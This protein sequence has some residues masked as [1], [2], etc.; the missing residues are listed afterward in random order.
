MNSHKYIMSK[1]SIDNPIDGTLKRVHTEVSDS[2]SSD[3]KS[4]VKTLNAKNS[5]VTSF[6][7][8][9]RFLIIGSTDEGALQKL[10]PFAIDKGLQGWAGSLK[11][12][13]KL[14][15]GTLLVECATDGH[16]RSLL[17]SG[18]LCNVPIKVTPHSS[19]NSCKGVIR[20]RD[21]EGVGEEEICENLTSQGV[22]GVKRINIRR[23]NELVP[24]NTLILTFNS[25]TLPN[26]VKAGYLNIPVVPYIPNR[27]RCFKCQTF[28]HGQNTCRSRLT[29]ARC[30]QVDHDS[31]TCQNDM[32]CDNCKGHH[33][34]FSRECPRWKVEKQVQQVNVE[35]HLSFYE[36]R[37][38]VETST[39]VAA[40]KSYAAAVKVSTTSIATQTDLTW[41][42]AEDKFKKIFDLKKAIKKAAKAAKNQNTK[43]TQVSLDSRNPSNDLTGE[44][45]PSKSKTG[46]DTKNQKKGRLKKI[47]R[48]II[49]IDNP[50]E[51][52]V[53][54]DDKNGHSP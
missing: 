28:G 22:V 39:P 20:S 18:L 51:S 54:M 10:S 47:E 26:S 43:S 8:W 45:G 4:T 6:K 25:P 53:N 38:L 11:S 35:K 31:K 36:A 3:E 27:L 29:C 16:S 2:T 50:F 46:K 7:T 13:K 19:L 12:V 1:K 32:A 44:P 15:N 41:P 24:T 9:P 17:K 48:N 34:A 21:L 23:N 40:S 37:E 52:L 5:K 14:R 33:F 30:G 42:N 49:P